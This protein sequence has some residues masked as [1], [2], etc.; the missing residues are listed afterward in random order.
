MEFL[1]CRKI[2][3]CGDEIQR[4]FAP[5]ELKAL[6]GLENYERR[7]TEMMNKKITA[8]QLASLKSKTNVRAGSD[9]NKEECKK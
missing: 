3:P 6:K 9:S 2:L 7:H 1:P 4:L 8:A 5:L